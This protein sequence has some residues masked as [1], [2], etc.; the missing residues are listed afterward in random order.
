MF[1]S[2]ESNYTNTWVTWLHV[3]IFSILKTCSKALI[4]MTTFNLVKLPPVNCQN[5]LNTVVIRRL[6][7]WK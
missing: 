3:F 6:N 2:T 1:P 7:T 4:Y 5:Y